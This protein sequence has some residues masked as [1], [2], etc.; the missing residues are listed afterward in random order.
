MVDLIETM[1]IEVVDGK[2]VLTFHLHD[3]ERPELC[4]DLLDT[5]EGA[6]VLVKKQVA[7]GQVILCIRGTE[8]IGGTPW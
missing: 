6:K 1:G 4:E 3:A 5:F 8:A 7:T 2:I